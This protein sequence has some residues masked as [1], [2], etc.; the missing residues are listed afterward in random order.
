MLE[1]ILISGIKK[2]NCINTK[3]EI[4]KWVNNINNVTDLKMQKS[5]LSENNYWYYDEINGEITNKTNSFFKINGICIQYNNLTI[6]QPIIIQKE[7][8]YLGILCKE[9]DGVLYF[10]MQAKIEP[11]NINKVQISPTLQATKSNFMQKHGGRKPHYLD[12][13]INSNKYNIIVDQLQSEQSSRFYGKRNRN[14]IIEVFDDVVVHDNFKWL[15]LGQ[16]KELLKEPN[17]VNMDTRTV[18]SCIPY[19]LYESSNV[20]NE[21]LITDKSLYNS[22]IESKNNIPQIYNYINDYK[23]FLEKKFEYIKL[24]EMENWTMSDYGIKCNI[25]YPFSVIYCDIELKGREVSNWF[26]PLFKAENKA[27]FGLFTTIVD[28]TR[29]FLINCLPELGFFDNI[30]LG[31]TVQ[32]ESKSC[33]MSYI[34]DLFLKCYNSDKYKK[35]ADV[36]L[37][38]E[39]GRF[40][41]EENNNIII[42][43]P[44]DL[45]KDLPKEY[46]WTNYK[47]LNLL[48]QVNNCLN[49]Q[50]R[51]LLSL[52]E[53]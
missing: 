44:F 5:C 52:L 2:N 1:K 14:I 10:L 16:I 26:Q 11:G 18:L 50:L 8:G 49:I 12:Y 36:I 40:Y 43:I 23:M 38:E 41:H 27:I 28:N 13:F 7:I 30:E 37:S 6:T 24:H 32:I 53:V 46:F 48:T 22:M 42:E 35:I 39:G 17:I 20:E 45:I 3:N 15:T 34:D 31:P 33:N 29:L 19:S 9:F 25:D 21:K 51:N 4:L 47:T